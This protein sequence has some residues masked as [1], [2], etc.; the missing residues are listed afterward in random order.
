MPALEIPAFGAPAAVRAAA[1][2]A[3]RIELNAQGSYAQGGITPTSQDLARFA[4]A[5]DPAVSV[6]VMI[7]P[8][9]P[10]ASGGRDFV[11]SEAEIEGMEASIRGFLALGLL[12]P[13][14]GDGFVFGV[15]A[16][17]GV[18]ER[19]WVDVERCARLVVAARP[20][21]CVFHRAFDE[22]VSACP[23]AW[24]AGLEA[25]AACG[26]DGILTSGGVGRA[27]DHISVLGDI[28]R[29][30]RD[31]R[32]E[33]IVGGGVRTGNVGELT[34][35]LGGAGLAWLHSACLRPG[36]EDVDPA[37]VEGLVARLGRRRD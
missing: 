8:R 15:L 18:G 20:F 33:I 17:D 21:R 5:A 31:L 35:G 13:E 25:V 19:C 16:E 2:G 36:G 34:R 23:G 11:Y 24:G 7:R 32:V 3:T 12:C 27:V 22:V 9:G 28:I 37:E 29:K 26:F 10:P 4:A 30:A 6:R 1:S 14:R